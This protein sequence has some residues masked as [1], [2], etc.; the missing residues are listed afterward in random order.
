MRG[1][2]SVLAVDPG[3]QWAPRLAEVVR[4]RGVASVWQARSFAE[5]G[6][7]LAKSLELVVTEVRIGEQRCFEFLNAVAQR[8]P[9]SVVVATSSDASLQ[10]VFNL[11]DHG[12]KWFLEQPISV[13][14]LDTFLDAAFAAPD[15]LGPSLCTVVPGC[16]QLTLTERDT[17]QHLLRGMSY[18]KIAASRRVSLNTVKTQVRSVLSKLGATNQR[19][20]LSQLLRDRPVG[21][22]S[23]EFPA[24]T[25]SDI[26]QVKS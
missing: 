5:A 3:A 10:E 13:Q 1:P 12:A 21:D 17:L 11:R 7:L 23:G 6:A 16:G 9:V 22:A 19:E 24:F 18:R 25:A 15:G 2:R 26:P 8:S 14:R 4:R 20:L